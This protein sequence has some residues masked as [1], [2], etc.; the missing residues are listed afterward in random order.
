MRAHGI[1][2]PGYRGCVVVG[3]LSS[4]TWIPVAFVAACVVSCDPDG[5]PASEHDEEDHV[6]WE[7]IDWGDQSAFYPCP[8]LFDPAEDEGCSYLGDSLDG[9]CEAID[10][11]RAARRAEG[12]SGY[13]SLGLGCCFQLSTIY[14]SPYLI[15]V[16]PE[17]DTLEARCEQFI[18]DWGDM[19]AMGGD[20]MG[21]A[22]ERTRTND[23]GGA[24][25][26]YHQTYFGVPVLGGR[27]VVHLNS[28]GHVS[29]AV[30]EFIA[31]LNDPPEPVVDPADAKAMAQELEP[32]MEAGE[33]ELVV[34]RM[35]EC[36][37]PRLAWVVYLYRPG[38]DH[39]WSAVSI[40]AITG[41]VL[42][43][44]LTVHID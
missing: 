44:W 30:G 29:S 3:R 39:P 19:W 17:E 23:L 4:G 11:L 28:E 13:L 35:P 32:D 24:L 41:E 2:A 9:T 5:E 38:W 20:G 34:H 22:H 31:R 43:Q 18:A 26:I 14:G 40:S 16:Q 8:S 27:F 10:R 15:S 36:R 33:P 6:G 37:E 21:L 42:A 25:C 7:P 12:A 1:M